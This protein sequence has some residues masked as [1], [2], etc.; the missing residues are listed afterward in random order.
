MM[1]PLPMG[2]GWDEGFKQQLKVGKQRLTFMGK[3]IGLE[4]L[5]EHYVL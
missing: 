1:L 4:M 3:E 2:E 5:L